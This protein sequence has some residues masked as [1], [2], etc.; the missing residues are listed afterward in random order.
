MVRC[1][2]CNRIYRYSWVDK[3]TNLMDLDRD[4]ETLPEFFKSEWE[5]HCPSYNNHIL[6][7]C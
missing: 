3:T 1:P 6:L 4:I 2:I 7:M 5:I